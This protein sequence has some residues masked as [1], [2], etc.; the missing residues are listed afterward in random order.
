M[1]I[2]HYLDRLRRLGNIHEHDLSLLVSNEDVLA[3]QRVNVNTGDSVL[4]DAFLNESLIE[5]LGFSVEHLKLS[6]RVSN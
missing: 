2:L 1:S 6:H 4:L 5:L 3:F